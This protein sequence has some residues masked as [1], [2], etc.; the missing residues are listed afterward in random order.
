MPQHSNC[1]AAIKSLEPQNGKGLTVV[2]E[3]PKGSRNKFKFSPELGLFELGSVLPAGLA[4]PYDFGFVPSTLAQDG[5]PLD[6]LLLMDEP[7][8]P[9]CL[10]AARIIGV[11]KAEQTERD[12]KTT[13]NDRLVAVAADAHDYADLR[14]VRDMNENLMK[15]L[16]HFFV[17]YNEMK[18]K[19]FKL[20][21][22]RGPSGARRV[23]KGAIAAA[24][25]ATRTKRKAK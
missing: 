23:L 14:S 7:A 2:I 9:G 13:R 10:V 1:L 19:R 17:S 11:I 8:F 18:G 15:E 16:E 3:T 4:F 21:G 22:C 12:G 20:L 24:R 6:V 5:D 25:K